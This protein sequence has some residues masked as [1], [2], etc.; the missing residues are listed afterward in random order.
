MN[1]DDIIKALKCQLGI[2][3]SNNCFGCL[4]RENKSCINASECI[5]GVVE[6]LINRQKA[7]IERLTKENEQAIEKW[8]ILEKRTKERYAELYE[9][10]KEVVRVKAIKEFWD[11][12]QKDFPNLFAGQHP[13]TLSEIDFLVK[14]LTEEQ[15]GNL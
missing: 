8:H 4:Y 13:C 7:E 14:E 6:D 9:E 1:V 10:A 11:R 3:T 15:N 2:D 12:L 5:L